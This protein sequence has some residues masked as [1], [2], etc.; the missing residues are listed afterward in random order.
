MWSWL[1]GPFLL[2]PCLWSPTI[3]LQVRCGS[4]TYVRSL[5]TGLAEL[6]DTQGHV[7]RLRRTSVG[8][9][10]ET[11][12]FS[13]VSLEKTLHS[14]G[15]QVL[16][17]MDVVLDDIPDIAVTEAEALMIRH[18]RPLAL[19]SPSLDEGAEVWFRP[20]GVRQVL[21]T[22]QVRGGQLCPVRVFVAP[23]GKN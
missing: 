12:A 3:P 7:I 1:H 9:F 19:R 18:G 16:K 4:G 20:E 5:A 6:L 15:G 14:E 22:G 8:P 13:L 21:A 11:C 10:D 23:P 17:P 2:M